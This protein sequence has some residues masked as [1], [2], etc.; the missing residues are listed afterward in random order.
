MPPFTN[1]EIDYNHLVW[2]WH[3]RLG[4]I[5]LDNLVRLLTLGEGIDVSEKQ[6]RAKL[7]VICPIY[8]T[9]K[10]VNRVPKDPA[11]CRWKRVGEMIDADT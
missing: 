4:H 10:A 8:A 3:R 7:A 11:T 5:G 6:I 2:L 9:T 1:P